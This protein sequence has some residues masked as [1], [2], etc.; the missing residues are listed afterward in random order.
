MPSQIEAL[1]RHLTGVVPGQTSFADVRPISIGRAR[2]RDADGSNKG[3][4]AIAVAPHS[5]PPVIDEGA[6]N[7]FKR[8]FILQ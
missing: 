6:R 7:S 8:R 5:A 3:R 1:P 2:R 4:A